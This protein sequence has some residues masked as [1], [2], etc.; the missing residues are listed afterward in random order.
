MKPAPA[1]LVL[2]V[3]FVSFCFIF[4]VVLVLFWLNKCQGVWQQGSRAPTV[5]NQLI[6]GKFVTSLY[7]SPTF[8]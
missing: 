2:F 8:A 6:K 1:F 5:H 7:K 3:S 4:F